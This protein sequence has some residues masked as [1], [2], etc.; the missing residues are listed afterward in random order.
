MPAIC[1]KTMST[2]DGKI[3]EISG[4]SVDE[5]VDDQ[6]KC[7]FLSHCHTDHMRG[8]RLLHTESPVYT[9]SIS[10]LL[11]RNKSPQ[12]ADKIRILEL[13]VPTAVDLPGSSQNFVVTALSAGHCAGSC[14]LLFQIEGCDILYTGDFRI[15]LK[16]ANNI[17]LLKEIRNNSSTVLYLDSTFLKLSFPSFPSQSESV[18]TIVDIVEKF[19]RK[20][21]NHKSKMQFY[22]YVIS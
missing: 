3:L 10:A 11:I 20:S 16:N 6:A 9:T 7:Y 21:M 14:M 12:L 1:D 22:D 17:K 13:G 8:L 4:I 2:F 5:F 15:S 19:L 18:T